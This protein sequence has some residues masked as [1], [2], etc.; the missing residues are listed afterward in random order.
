MFTE[1]YLGNLKERDH[2]E[3]I[4]QWILEKEGMM[5]THHLAQYM[6]L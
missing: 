2:L 4:D 3:A 1:F 6:D 5:Y